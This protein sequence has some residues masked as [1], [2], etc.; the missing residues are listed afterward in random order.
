M[1]CMEEKFDPLFLLQQK[2]NTAASLGTASAAFLDALK[3]ATNLF[4]QFLVLHSDGN[5]QLRRKNDQT[6]MLL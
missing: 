3:A 4:S 5:L 1:Q 6:S 2:P